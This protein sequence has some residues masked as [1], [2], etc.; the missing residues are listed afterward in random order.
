MKERRILAQGAITDIES[1][2]DHFREYD[3]S[4]QEAQQHNEVLFREE[5][6]ANK[7]NHE[8]IRQYEQA[9]LENMAT[10]DPFKTKIS[11]MSLSKSRSTLASSRNPSGGREEIVLP[12]SKYIDIKESGIIIEEKPERLES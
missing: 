8:E 9:H 4:L 3:R 7:R 5:R 12:P 2:L 11:A 1:K 6:E 10:R